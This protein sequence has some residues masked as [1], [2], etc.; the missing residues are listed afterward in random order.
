[1]RVLELLS[2]LA[3]S[4]AIK[5]NRVKD[6]KTALN[7]L[8][9]AC[10]L[11]LDELDLASI[12]ATYPDILKSYF[13]TLDP[14]PTEH[15][16]RNT[17]QNLGQLYRAAHAASLLTSRVR[18]NRPRRR[19]MRAVARDMNAQSPYRA[20]RIAGASAHYGIPMAQWP[21]A[22]VQGWQSYADIKTFQVRQVTM[23]N[24]TDLMCCYLGYNLKHDPQPPERWEQLFEITRIVRCLSWMAARV[25]ADRITRRGACLVVALVDIASHQDRPEYAALQ[26]FKRQLPDYARLYDK[27]APRH[28]VSL[29]EIDHLGSTLM[30][31]ARQY[32]PH[33]TSG[34]K[35]SVTFATGLI[36][37]L[38]VRCPRRSREIRE[39]DLGGRLYQDHRDVWQLYYK[40]H[41]LKIAEHDGQPNEFRMEWPPD[42][43]SDLTEY[44]RVHRPRILTHA[45][46]NLVFPT[47][48]GKKISRSE[49]WRRI[50]I[51]C[52]DRLHKHVY[53]H[54][55]RM[56]WCDAYLDAHPGDFEGAAAMLNDTEATVRSWYRQ[57]RV[58]QQLK[59]GTD[60]N[61]QLFGNGKRTAR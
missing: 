18:P 24:Y 2:S 15:T 60:F 31:E 59:K 14:I 46:S 25:G 56:L 52:W 4:G 30:A 51:P 57:F 44:F 32:S 28:T 16:T 22:I 37:R 26:K 58:E 7:K 48:H 38:L 21:P 34:I 23:E 9:Q 5:Q 11:P 41:Q 27:K 12:E 13:D 36:I 43:V 17:Y 40:S 49:F 3:S 47:Q 54:L 39:M 45:T 8:S 42:L 29:I 6:I 50:A 10:Q 55:F 33:V 19:N 61:A 53:P 1:M 20:H 35:R